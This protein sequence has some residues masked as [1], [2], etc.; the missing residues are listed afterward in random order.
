MF[1][2]YQMVHQQVDLARSQFPMGRAAELA[3]H[4]AHSHT[5]RL[6]GSHK[7]APLVTGDHAKWG[8]ISVHSTAKE[9]AKIGAPRHIPAAARKQTCRR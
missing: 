3:S 5:P 8:L 4:L 1:F 7:P 2:R 9:I 6:C